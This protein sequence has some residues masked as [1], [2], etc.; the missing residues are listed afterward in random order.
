MAIKPGSSLQVD[1]K[2]GFGGGL[3]NSPFEVDRYLIGVV[4]MVKIFFSMFF[5]FYRKKRYRYEDEPG[6]MKI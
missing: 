2:L 1:E 4:F 5:Y 3:E 6:S